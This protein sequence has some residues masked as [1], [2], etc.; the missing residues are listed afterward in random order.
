MYLYLRITECL[1]EGCPFLYQTKGGTV[2]HVAQN[3]VEAVRDWPLEN[4]KTHI[5]AFVDGDKGDCEPKEFLFYPSV[6]I[7]VATS[8]RGVNQKWVWQ[9]ESD[10]ET[11][12]AKLA[13]DLWSPQELFLTGLV[14]AFLLSS[15]D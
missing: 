1:I 12:F 7:I 11:I 9:A 13:T 4:P 10:Y 8:P 3:G 5:M 14:L 2:Y 6:Q 15:L